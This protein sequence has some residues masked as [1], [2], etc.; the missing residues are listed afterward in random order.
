MNIVQI[1]N[2]KNVISYDSAPNNSII[3]QIRNPM[4]KIKKNDIDLNNV[5][6]I[7]LLR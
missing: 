5:F 7:R 1:D 2:I 4:N 6:I 3:E